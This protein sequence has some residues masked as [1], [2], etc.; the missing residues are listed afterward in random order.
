MAEP[1]AETRLL[2]GAEATTQAA[3]QTAAQT[4]VQ[5]AAQAFIAAT[6]QATSS[7]LAGGDEADASDAS[8]DAQMFFGWDDTECP[9]YNHVITTLHAMLPAQSAELAVL[10]TW[11]ES[12]H[13]TI[14]SIKIGSAMLSAAVPSL[15]AYHLPALLF[16]TRCPCLK[17]RLLRCLTSMMTT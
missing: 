6:H 17:K 14:P 8:M 13:F 3:A 10:T 9:S 12:P 5:T 2:P 4:A 15:H 1:Q 7:V 16:L 11:A